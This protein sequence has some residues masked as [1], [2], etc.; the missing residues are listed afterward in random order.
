[1]KIA[2]IIFFSY[3]DFIDNFIIF[4]NSVNTM[5]NLNPKSVSKGTVSYVSQVHRP[6][7]QLIISNL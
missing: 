7:I 2:R 5:P 4:Y 1:M 6:I 3:Y